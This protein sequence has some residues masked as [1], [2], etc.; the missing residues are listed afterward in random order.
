MEIANM[1][2]ADITRKLQYGWDLA[3][4]ENMEDTADEWFEMM[5]NLDGLF[6]DKA[7]AYAA[8]IS[9][10]NGN[11]DV[12]KAEIDRLNARK[13]AMENQVDRIK[14]RLKMFMEINDKTKFKTALHSYSIQ[15]N[16][17]SVVLDCDVR[18]LPIELQVFKEPTPDK[19][20]I[21]TIL[22]SGTP[23]QWAHLEQSTSL[24]I[25]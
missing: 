24:R 10:I 4:D 2:M 20:A 8:V 11:I 19:K 15:K 21:K 7:D 9:G 23:F 16:P 6:E 12:I 22:E 1:S 14:A 5:E 25:R 3:D 17:A 18:D 13:K